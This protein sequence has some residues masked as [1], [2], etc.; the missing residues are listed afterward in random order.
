MRKIKLAVIFGG[1]STEHDVSIVSGA[2]VLNN[3]DKEKYEI[4]PI[5]ID[6]Q[7]IW[8]KYVGNIETLSTLHVG[9]KIDNIEK[10]ENPM[11]YLKKCD[12][13]FPVLH[14]L[15]GEDGTIQGLLEL[16][17]IRYVGC[18]VLASSLAMDKAYTKMVFEKA[19]LKQ[20]KYVF[21]YKTNNDEYEFIED[22]VV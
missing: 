10:I 21:I 16:L 15:Y 6:A 9:G 3:L 11:E 22:N 5:Y 8:N 14:G 7:G 17:K 20:A 1:M 4:F 18:K 12:I 19:G 13:A 2:S